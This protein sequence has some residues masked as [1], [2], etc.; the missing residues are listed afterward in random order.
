MMR[1][2]LL[3]MHHTSL[4]GYSGPEPWS[5]LNDPNDRPIWDTATAA[6]ARYVVSHNTN[7][8][9]PLVDGRHIW[10]GIEYLT[11]IEFIDDVLGEDII[12]LIPG[13]IAPSTLLRSARTH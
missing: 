12:S 13:P 6:S 10:H 5:T 8:F 2:L 3:V 11:A 7:D 4:R 1:H 9:P